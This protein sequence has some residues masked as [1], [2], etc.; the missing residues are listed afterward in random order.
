MQYTEIFICNIVSNSAG[1]VYYYDN[2]L[3]NSDAIYIIA[4]LTVIKLRYICR[5]REV[6]V[7]TKP[8]KTSVFV[9]LCHVSLSHEAIDR[10]TC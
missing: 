3:Q 10:F 7:P 6:L 5:W 1:I 2:V 4:L 8:I 9:G